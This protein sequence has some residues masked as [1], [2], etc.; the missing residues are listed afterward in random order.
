MKKDFAKVRKGQLQD[1]ILNMQPLQEIVG[2][3][4]HESYAQELLTR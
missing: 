2:Q 3:F 1:E 4:R